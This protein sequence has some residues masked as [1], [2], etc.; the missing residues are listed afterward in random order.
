MNHEPDDLSS[1]LKSWH[2][3]VEIPSRFQA[4]VW[5]RIAGREEARSRSLWRR[6]RE[7]LL[8]E[9]GRPAYA[10]A[11]LI[12]SISLSLGV[13]HVQAESAKANHWRE[14][15]TRYVRSITPVAHPST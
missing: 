7:G 12:V 13:A 3:E 4:G 6:L 15:E 5:Q 10:T 8:T 14:L 2:V 11:L 9:M 1:K